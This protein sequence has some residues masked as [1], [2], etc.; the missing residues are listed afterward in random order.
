MIAT[1]SFLLC[2]AVAP[3]KPELMSLT[4]LRKLLEEDVN[5]HVKLPSRGRT[6]RSE[7]PDLL[8]FEKGKPADCFILILEG[9][10]EVSIG[11]ENMLF[12]GRPFTSF[13]KE[14]FL[15]ISE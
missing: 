13:G 6:P 3:F 1:D 14:F 10:V 2:V 11:N 15:E 4:A 7:P 8:L 9:L 12:I 5:R